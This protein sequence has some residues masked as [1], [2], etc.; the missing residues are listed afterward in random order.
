M[1][2]SVAAVGVV[3][4]EPPPVAERV[5]YV[6]SLTQSSALACPLVTVCLVGCAPLQMRKIQLTGPTPGTSMRCKRRAGIESTF[7]Q[8]S[9]LVTPFL[10]DKDNCLGVY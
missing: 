5:V 1:R 3:L 2:N 7:P 10:Q 4:W 9:R 6:R 8:L